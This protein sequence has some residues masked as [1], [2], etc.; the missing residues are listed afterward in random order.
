MYCLNLKKERMRGGGGIKR[1]KLEKTVDP[2]ELLE[3]A[4]D[5]VCV[6]LG[7]A[8]ETEVCVVCSLLPV[9]ADT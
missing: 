4:D 7:E 5:G 2:G 8:F 1:K 9:L 6:E 3:D